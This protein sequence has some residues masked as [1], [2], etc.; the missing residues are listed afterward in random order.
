MVFHVDDILI[1]CSSYKLLNKTI[2]E[3][4]ENFS[5]INIDRSQNISYLGMN[6]LRM[7]NNDLAISS[8]GYIKSC[9][10]FWGKVPK[11]ATVPCNSD[12]F[13]VDE[14]NVLLSITDKRRFHT[15]VAKMLY[16]ACKNRPDILM[17]C[18]Y[19]ASRVNEPNDSDMKKIDRL[20]NYIDSTKDM[21]LIYKYGCPI[22]LKVYS[23]ASYNIHAD[24]TSRSGVIALLGGGYISSK[25]SKQHLITRSSTEAEL[26]ALD[27]GNTM[28]LILINIIKD[29]G[30]DIEPVI[31][32]EDNKSTI[33]L[34]MNGFAKG[35]TTRTIDSKY[36]YASQCVR[37]G[38]IELEFC[39]TENMIA[40]MLTKPLIKSAFQRIRNMVLMK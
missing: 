39:N 38:K 27:E 24:C 3:I 29:M 30:I 10:E 12:L 25:S 35:Y 33:K 8:V 26:V 31:M 6:I 20:Y 5:D 11:T 36:F 34:I 17:V 21:F 14:E 9:I 1:S 22:E 28:A 19:L 4:K 40:D 16:L 23:D 13:K 2:D 15:L 37:L 7:D 18:S 32:M